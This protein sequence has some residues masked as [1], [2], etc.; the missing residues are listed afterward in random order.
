MSSKKSLLYP[1]QI[2]AEQTRIVSRCLWVVM[3]LEFEQIR[4]VEYIGS[5]P[6]VLDALK[7]GCPISL[8]PVFESVK[9][10]LSSTEG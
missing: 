9:C 10:L 3:V 6:R 5:G 8:P 7:S 2:T 1:T 4:K